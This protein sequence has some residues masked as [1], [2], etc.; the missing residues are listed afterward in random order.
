M[1]IVREELKPVKNFED[2]TCFG[3]GSKNPVGLRMEFLTDDTRLYSFVSVPKTMT[4]W[5]S[6]VHGGILTTILDEMMGWSVIYLLGKIGVTKS[7]TVDFKKPVASENPLM[8]VGSIQ[9]V[10]SERKAIVTGEIYNQDSILCVQSTGTFASMTA[11]A[12]VRLGVMGTDYMERFLPLLRQ[13]DG[14]T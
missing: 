5:D 3:C 6:T 10:V 8:A 4:G 14:P 1:E 13:K 9:E 7:I 11:Q 2:Q 12:A